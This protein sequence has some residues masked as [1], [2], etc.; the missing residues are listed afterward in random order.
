MDATGG[1]SP[2]MTVS[3]ASAYCRVARSTLWRAT[4]QGRLK[5]YGPGTA[6][7]YRRDELDKF[8]D[9]RNR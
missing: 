7:R 9:A 5:Q 8:M 2:Y 4:K 6:V 3:E 1:D